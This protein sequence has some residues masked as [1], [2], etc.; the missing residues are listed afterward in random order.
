M[1]SWKLLG[2]LTRFTVIL[3]F[4]S[5]IYICLRFLVRLPEEANFRKDIIISTLLASLSSISECRYWED[6]HFGIH[7][8]S[9]QN[10]VHT[11]GRRQ[12]SST[13]PSP[14]GWWFSKSVPLWL[15]FDNWIFAVTILVQHPVCQWCLWL[16]VLR[17][18]TQCS[19]VNIL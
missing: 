10:T 2:F 15:A 6:R 7:S 13:P 9:P 12:N 1:N 3:S 4:I 8:S 19:S 17:V 14:T 11:R 5:F 16:L 18:L